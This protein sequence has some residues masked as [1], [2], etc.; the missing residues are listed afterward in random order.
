MEYQGKDVRS[1]AIATLAKVAQLGGDGGVICLDRLGHVAME[2]NTPG[3]Y[4]AYHVSGQAPVV[5]IYSDESAR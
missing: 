3:M 2:F 4:R 1:A 5:A